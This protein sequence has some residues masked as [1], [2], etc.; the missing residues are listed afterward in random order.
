MLADDLNT[1]EVIMVIKHMITARDLS[2]ALASA[3]IVGLRAAIE[4]DQSICLEVEAE[5]LVTARLEARKAKDWAE[6]DRIRDELAA[7]GILLKDGK[8]PETG[9]PLTT[10]ELA[11]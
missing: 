2:G 8:D 11:R 3:E 7:K 9:E 5:Q 1:S 6:A 4:L 10:W